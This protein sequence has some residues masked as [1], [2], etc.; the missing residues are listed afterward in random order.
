VGPRADPAKLQAFRDALDR[1]LASRNED[2]EER[3]KVPTGLKEP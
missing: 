2:Y 3:R 1:E